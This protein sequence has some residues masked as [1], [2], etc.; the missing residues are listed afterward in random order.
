MQ[1]RAAS[2]LGITKLLPQKLS[3]M[4]LPV[5]LEIDLPLRIAANPPSTVSINRPMWSGSVCPR[6]TPSDLK[7]APAS[8]I[9]ARVL[10]RSRVERAKRS[11]FVTTTVSPGSSDRIQRQHWTDIPESTFMNGCAVLSIVGV[12]PT[13]YGSGPY[14]RGFQ[15]DPDVIR[16]P[17]ARVR[18][19]APIS[20]GVA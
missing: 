14:Q 12:P 1:S 8:P 11:S 16:T 19:P 18:H 10:S 4:F 3:E 2:E 9:A 15:P 6:I 5:S 17:R 13:R 7:L 20:F